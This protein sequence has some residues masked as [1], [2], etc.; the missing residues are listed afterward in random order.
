MHSELG[1]GLLEMGLRVASEVSVPICYRGVQIE[2]GFR[3]D[4]VVEDEVV[5][6][7]K[8]AEEIKPV[9]KK[10]LLTY[11]KLMHKQVG[12]LINFNVALLKDGIERLVNGMD[13]APPF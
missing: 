13:E 10:Q 9:H 1:P 11:L 12:L 5:V 7:L 4:L 6:E 2:E 8:A 3:A